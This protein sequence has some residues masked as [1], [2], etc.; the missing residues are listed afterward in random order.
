MLASHFKWALINKTL[1]HG[2][3]RS[4]VSL[5]GKIGFSPLGKM[6]KK[7]NRLFPSCSGQKTKQDKKIVFSIG[8]SDESDEDEHTDEHINCR[9]LQ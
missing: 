9:L 2:S 8:D 4:S 1:K 7:F 5:K 6:A 3:S